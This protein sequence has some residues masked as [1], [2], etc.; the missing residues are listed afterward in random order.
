MSEHVLQEGDH[1]PEIVLDDDQARSFQLSALKGKN[2]VLY[3]Y[4]KADTPG[5]T[6]EACEFRDSSGP[7]SDFKKQGRLALHFAGRD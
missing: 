7:Q 6:K 5:W 2:V 3:F 4:P 1:A